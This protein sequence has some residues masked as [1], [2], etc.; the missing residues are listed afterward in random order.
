MPR[1]R[2]QGIGEDEPAAME[3]RK[4]QLGAIP[5]R[6]FEEPPQS[7][8]E[9]A[10]SVIPNDPPGDDSSLQT[11]QVGNV[12]SSRPAPPLS[13]VHAAATLARVTESR[14]AACR[15][16]STSARSRVSASSAAARA[17][18]ELE[19][20]LEDMNV[21]RRRLD[22]QA[23][24]I[25]ER[26]VAQA[27]RE[28]ADASER[29]S[30]V[31]NPFETTVRINEWLDKRDRV[32]QQVE[33]P[34]PLTSRDPRG[35]RGEGAREA[36]PRVYANH[37]TERG[38]Y[39]RERRYHRSPSPREDRYERRHSP[40]SPPRT[41]GRGVDR[42][43]DALEK[44][45]MFRPPPRQAQELPIFT[46]AYTDWLP[47]KRAMIDSTRMYKFS[48][49]ENLARLRVSLKGEAKEAVAALLY[50]ASNPSVIMDTLE[51]CFGKPELIV[52][53]TVSELR[54]LPR[55]DG[56]ATGLNSFAVKV[57]NV[58]C[59][60]GNLAHWHLYDSTL[61][62]DLVE[63]LDTYRQTKWCEYADEHRMET[64]P[65]I[66]KLSRFLMRE[67]DLAIR[68]LHSAAKETAPARHDPKPRPPRTRRPERKN[69]Y[70][71]T[72]ENKEPR[73]SV[74]L[75]CGGNHSVPRCWKFSAMTVED[76]W[77]WAKEA[78]VCFKC[79]I[80]KHRRFNCRAKS[81]GVDGCDSPHHALLH[82]Q[83]KPV[84]KPETPKVETVLNT[85][86][87]VKENSGSVLLKVCPVS[88]IGPN[89]QRANTYAL[90]DEGST[91]TLIDAE[92]ADRIGADGPT[93]KLRIHGLGSSQSE[94]TSKAV[95]LSICG[96]SGESH[97]VIARTV[98]NL[99][100]A[101]QTID[102]SCLEYAHLRGLDRSEVCYNNV[103]PGILVG[104]DNW[105]LIVSRQ[106]LVGGRREPVASLT[107]LGWTVHGTVPKVI[108]STANENVFHAYTYRA[109]ISRTC[110]DLDERL[111]DRMKQHFAIDSIGISKIAK[112]SRS[113]ERALDI[114]AR[115]A[116]RI[117]HQFEVGLPWK[118]DVVVMPPSYDMALRRLR[119]IERKM[120]ASPE[121]KREYEAQVQNLLDKGYAEP[122]QGNEADSPIGWYL[123]HFAVRNVNK[124]G[125]L[126][127]VHD[128][129]ATVNGTCLNDKL[130]DGPD[131]LR[132]LPGVLF[133]F[134]ERDV[135]VSADIREMFMRIKIRKA[136]QPAQMFLWR[137]DN[138][139]KP[140][141]RYKMTSMIFGARSSPFL[142][143]SVRN[144][145]AKEH[146]QFYPVAFDAITSNH[147]MD[148]WVDSYENEARAV[149]AV[150]EVV[151][152]QARA[153]FQLAGWN[154]NSELVLEHV[155]VE[156]RGRAAKELGGSDP[157]GAGKTL[158][159]LWEASSDELRFNT[160]MNR[161]PRDV[162]SLKRGP[163]KREAL[164]AVMSIF[165]PLG[166]L[167]YYTIRAKIVLQNVWRSNVGWDDVL[168]E[169]ENREFLDWLR[170]MD[171]VADLRLDR[172]YGFNKDTT[173]TQ[174]HVFSD[175]SELA[176]ATA[177]Y[178][179]I[180]YRNGEVK[181]TLA[182]AKAKV[183]PIRAPSIPRL[184]LQANLVGARLADSIL[185]EHRV[186]I[187]KV[188]FWSDSKTALHWIRN[189]K[190]RYT[191]YVAHRLSDISEL[192]RVDQWRWV[193]TA[194]NVADDAT[195]ISTDMKT[196]RDRWFIG[197][198]FLYESEDKWPTER[199]ES[200]ATE[201]EVVVSY[202]N[203]KGS[204]DHL[205][206]ISRFSSYERLIRTTTRVLA[207]VD[208][209]RRRANRVELRHVQEAERLWLLKSQHDDFNEE[210]A[211][212]A[213][214]KPLPRS[215]K[216]FKLDPVIGT[217]GI[218]R[219]N[220]R[221]NAAQI[222]QSVKSPAVLDGRNAFTRL[223]IDNIHR[224][225]G[226]GGRERV[227]NDVRQTYYV[228]RLRSTVRT[229]LHGCTFCRIKKVTPF[230]PAFGDLPAAR[231]D[232][233]S[234]PF[235]NCGV[236]YFG[237]M[238]VTI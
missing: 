7:P 224:R 187:D 145:N 66:V 147:Y 226:H 175:A 12:E 236:D 10:A 17:R 124:P 6:V 80:E 77:K 96:K 208:M 222:E 24:L 114:F 216:L 198:A 233:Y 172:K 191:P 89:G 117:G 213:R 64:E 98:H 75:C 193:P 219:V 5:P 133:R 125:K 229:V 214:K 26:L 203:E 54:R 42:L 20:E 162:R 1:T 217:D 18:A 159:L 234:P 36:P 151:T 129:A 4:Q 105:H 194:D 32:R 143:H 37:R 138:R 237:P 25:Q 72:A 38:E 116:K 177:A 225:S 186:P 102:S 204:F 87:L 84:S 161:V 53:R 82:T 164:S 142:A 33:L 108:N 50:T 70:N 173:N 28:E 153:G 3:H 31:E 128:A 97:K 215:S 65:E 206:D 134:R 185:R 131:L 43:V 90:L 223:C 78:Y 192:T 29:E 152:V 93:R 126:R 71:A 178:W 79:L 211:C 62:R 23:A 209:C 199:E 196:S 99:K 165:D 148:D 8:S 144:L 110:N 101:R 230:V 228:L 61:V 120:D 95:E 139:T 146:A 44:M 166:L 21:R 14:P 2:S 155:P 49:A 141:T 167:S 160:A 85:S 107:S 119:T 122:C 169:T 13:N 76:R 227:A 149:Q 184:E 140:P 163:T 22:L 220:G 176:Y 171:S 51:Q 118:D 137:G 189:D 207:F 174:L 180:T 232:A 39:R 88:V 132:S 11:N 103:K 47:F 52:E 35:E 150:A 183:T 123:P 212:L 111:E 210:I 30:V 15:V 91:V 205:P 16:G 154:S 46:G 56:T 69:V 121:F 63:K 115:T 181:V 238:I 195:R 59:V 179:R 19:A 130:L 135:A 112:P 41:K 202:A 9:L 48:D 109:D 73:K 40:K 55:P 83:R 235:S 182:A 188:I 127:L 60:L 100:L 231:L 136:D 57:Q 168:P 67:G 170:D 113:E 94:P 157:H 104:A 200:V 156:A 197:P 218:V 86:V 201:D 92:I 81:C 158:G 74:C 27:A 190:P 58:A 221:I 34:P 68:Y 106:L 45:A